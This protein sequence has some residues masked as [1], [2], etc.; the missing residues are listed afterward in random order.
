MR[1][2]LADWADA[3]GRLPPASSFAPGVDHIVDGLLAAS[4]AVVGILTV[5]TVFI[6]VRYRRGSS[7]YR[8]PVQTENWKIEAAWTT[9]T[10]LVF[11]SF[12]V[13]GART[14]LEMHRMP[15]GMEEITVVG[16]QWMWDVRYPDGR[17]EFNALHVRLGTPVRLLLSSEDVIHSFFVPAFRLKQDLVPGKVVD[18]WFK[19]TRAGTYLLYCAQYCGT[20][21]SEMTGKV[22]VLGPEEFAAWQA[23]KG[24]ATGDRLAAAVRGRSLFLKFGCGQCHGGA[25]PGRAPALAGV[26][27]SLVRLQDGRVVRADDL[28]LHDS[29]LLAPKYVVAGYDLRMPAYA[30]IIGEAEALDL[31]TYLKTLRPEP[32]PLVSLP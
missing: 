3:G 22:V 11:L 13:A 26:Y 5:L 14:Y 31:V 21:H 32:A 29:I 30:G 7:A 15:A 8:G 6:L 10:T 1:A 19:P 2:L 25:I 24:T 12:F 17:R 27:Q 23:G 28:Y 20:A 4:F 18:A 16:R 9:F